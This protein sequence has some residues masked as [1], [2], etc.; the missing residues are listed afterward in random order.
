[1]TVLVLVCSHLGQV[2]EIPGAAMRCVADLCLNPASIPV[3]VE[4]EGA[5]RIVVTSCPET[6][7]ADVQA[8]VLQAGLDPLGLQIQHVPSGNAARAT[9]MLEAAVARARA[10][11]GSQPEHVKQRRGEMSRRSFLRGVLSEYE[12]APAVQHSQCAVDKGCHAC[13]DVCPQEA[14]RIENGRIVH[15]TELCRPCGRC[16]TACPTGATVNP[17]FTPEIL[18]AHMRALLCD[19]D[20]EAQRGI[21]F[22]CSRSHAPAWWED[23]NENWFPVSVPCVSMLAP[24]WIIA[25]LLLGAGS[26]TVLHCDGDCPGNGSDDAA[27]AVAASRAVLRAAGLPQ[28]LVTN[29][30]AVAEPPGSGLGT[31]VLLEGPFRHDAHARI[32]TA[33]AD[34]AGTEYRASDPA[35]PVGLIINTEACTV[36]GSCAARCPTLALGFSEDGATGAR[37]TFD[38]SLCAACGQCEQSCPERRAGAIAMERTVDVSRLREGRSTLRESEAVPCRRCGRT[39]GS[40]A[41]MD[42][43]G[44]MLGG[45]NAGIPP[46]MELCQDCRGVTP[47]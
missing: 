22:H 39:V 26:V 32:F 31:S 34:A 21:A 11:A 30:E 4:E 23:W 42:R 41:M 45:E 12:A 10:F 35:L 43:L 9:A 15:D 1:M 47:G 24:S 17:A 27:A 25:P 14:I 29:A 20:G 38:A 19:A 7:V 40:R 8:H 16:V 28:D 13:V 44:A 37:L 18:D 46:W 36:C 33:L 5:E 3:A 6:V 2:E